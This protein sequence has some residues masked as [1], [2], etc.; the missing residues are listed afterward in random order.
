MENIDIEISILTKPEKLEY[1]D[2]DNLLLQ[3]KPNIDGVILQKKHHK[4]TFLPQ[5]WEQLPDVKEFL[6]HLCQKAGLSSNE[7][8]KGEIEIMTYQVEYF[9]E[10]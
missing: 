6:S 5:V 4:A 1:S 3:L 10:K 9:K 2:A 7:W 8:K